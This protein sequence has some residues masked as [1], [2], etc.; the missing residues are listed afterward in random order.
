MRGNSVDEDGAIGTRDKA[1]LVDLG[2][3]RSVY[4]YVRC[5][6]VCAFVCM[7]A[8]VCAQACMRERACVKELK[9]TDMNNSYRSN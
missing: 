3:Y 9:Y 5:V 6:C 2:P 8:S 4:A 1:S 7:G